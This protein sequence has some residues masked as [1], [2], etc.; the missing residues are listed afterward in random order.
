MLAV[1]SHHHKVVSKCHFP[2]KVLH[3]I[4][5]CNKFVQGLTIRS[6]SGQ[7]SPS[8]R[9]MERSMNFYLVEWTIV[10]FSVSLALFL[11]IDYLLLALRLT[12]SCSVSLALLLATDCLTCSLHLMLS[13]TDSDAL[14][15]LKKYFLLTL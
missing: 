4:Q 6:R 3:A 14:H 5:T 11:L 10:S 2:V 8:S 12:V 1:D 13:S 9:K 15:C 7:L